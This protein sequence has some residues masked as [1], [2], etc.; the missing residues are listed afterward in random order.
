MRGK[1]DNQP[2]ALIGQIFVFVFRYAVTFISM[3]GPS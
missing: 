2:P 1:S 3:I